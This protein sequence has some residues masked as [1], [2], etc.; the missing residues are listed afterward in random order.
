MTT[1]MSTDDDDDDEGIRNLMAMLMS[2]DDGSIIHT[3]VCIMYN[4]Q[5][6]DYDHAQ[7]S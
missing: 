1:T 5:R 6:M 2:I 4:T 3:Y 7:Y